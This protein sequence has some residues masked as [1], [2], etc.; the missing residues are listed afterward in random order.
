MR[1]VT[2]SKKPACLAKYGPHWKK[3]LLKAIAKGDKR[4]ISLARSKYNHPDVR[5]ALDAM[6]RNLCCYC[7][8]Q[9][10]AVRADEIEHRRPVKRFPARAFVWENVHLACSGCNGSKSD[11]WN[12]TH[13]ILDAVADKPITRHLDYQLSQTGVWEVALTDRGR[14]TV[15]HAN[16]NREKLRQSRGAVMLG[17]LGSIREIKQRGMGDPLAANSVA[18]LR[19]MYSEQYG[20]MTQWAVNA[21]L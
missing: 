2:R 3:N 13:P 21:F 12:K 5:Q 19:A 10:G 18:Q 9:V 20:S 6:Y 14:T 1:N 4:A 8:S 15:D 11:K 7:E 16:L 17:I